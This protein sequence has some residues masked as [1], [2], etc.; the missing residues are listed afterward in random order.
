MVIIDTHSWGIWQYQLSTSRPQQKYGKPRP[1]QQSCFI[2]SCMQYS[3]FSPNY[4]NTQW[5][6]KKCGMPLCQK[7][8]GHLELCAHE[9]MHSNHDIIWC[10]KEWHAGTKFKMPEKLW[11]LSMMAKGSMRC[12]WRQRK[13]RESKQT[14][15]LFL[16]LFLLPYHNK[17]GNAQYEE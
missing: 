10:K 17:V 1:R 5:M 2:C 8:R 3:L 7:D 4:E 15:Q 13:R 16:F 14:L 12:S 6:C 11:G 9:H